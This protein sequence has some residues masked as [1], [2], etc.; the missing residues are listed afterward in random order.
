VRGRLC[1]GEEHGPAGSC[2][3]PG[4]WQQLEPGIHSRRAS[5]DAQPR[6]AATPEASLVPAAWVRYPDLATTIARLSIG[7]LG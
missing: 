3:G 4:Q 6:C 5:P 7:R 1:K 2:C